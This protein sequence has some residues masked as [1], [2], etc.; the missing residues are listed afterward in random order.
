MRHRLWLCCRYFGWPE[1]ATMYYRATGSYKN[2]PRSWEIGVAL[3]NSLGA[4]YVVLKSLR[5]CRER[6]VIR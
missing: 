6:W 1:K 5:L 3:Y 2:L 4:G